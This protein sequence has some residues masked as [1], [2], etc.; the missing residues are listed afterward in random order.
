MARKDFF[1]KD[2]YRILDISRSAS[3][4]EIKKTFRRLALQC[5]P[6]RNPGDS[7]AEEKFKKISEAYG[8]LIDPEKRRRYDQI[9]DYGFDQGAQGND[10]GY[11]QE[12]IFRDVFSSPFAREV[13]RD[14]TQAFSESGFRS[15]NR[16]FNQVFFGGKG[17][18]FGGVFFF[19]PG[20]FTRTSYHNT[21]NKDM[22]T[23][24]TNSVQKKGV[25]GKLGAKAAMFLLNKFLSPPKIKEEK[26][27]YY[28]L[29]ITPEEAATGTEKQIAVKRREKLEKIL[30][31]IPPG[32]NPGTYLRLKGK[33]K[34]RGMGN[35]SGDLF[36]HI[37]TKSGSSGFVVHKINPI[38]VL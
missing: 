3:D 29:A 8:V 14:L 11:T 20:G 1:T 15:D 6:D 7:R 5:H 23:P 24:T 13:F 9:R 27:L 30:V 35:H 19:G 33:G 28:C 34:E 10:F 2:Y 26:D 17:V 4:E 36:L 25:I 18:V 16:F 32:L 22:V 31:K 21:F 12:D 38:F 37:V